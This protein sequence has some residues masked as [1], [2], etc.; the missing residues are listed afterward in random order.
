MNLILFGPPGA[1]KG[2]QAK[3]LEETRGLTQISTGDMFRK[4]IAEGSALGQKVKAIMDAGQLVPDDVT[5]A[6]LAERIDRPDCKMGF[7]LD[8]FPR[9]VA[10][11]EALDKMLAEKKI[12]LSAVIELKVNEP[13]LIERLTGRFACA[14]CGANYHGKFKPTK[15]RDV[16]DVCGNTSFSCRADDKPE[17]VGKRFKAYREQTEPLLPYY[18]RKN[19]LH[20]VDGMAEMDDVTRQIDAVLGSL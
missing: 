17:V 18:A 10:Q 11:A 19:L 2:T 12:P 9:T 13:M 1:G 4:A 6:M 7:I 15:V 8:G 16:C 5:V 20:T 14:K 3:R